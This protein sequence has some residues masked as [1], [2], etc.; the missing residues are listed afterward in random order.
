MASSDL[1]ICNSAL[2]EVPTTEIAALTETSLQAR[3]CRRSY[4]K[5]K[6][7]L[8][9]LPVRGWSFARGREALAVVANDRATEWRHAYRLPSG[10]EPLRI[11]AVPASLDEPAPAYAFT[12]LGTVKDETPPYLIAGDT[13]YTNVPE[14]HLDYRL[15]NVSEALF[16][17]YFVRALEMEL[18]SRLVMPITKDKVRWREVKAEAKVALDRALASDLNREPQRYFEHIPDTILARI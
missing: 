9:G 15:T 2:A 3:E 8:L 1:Q 12:A 17:E 11:V 16:P 4:A 18:A 10:K 7:Y 13:I 6:E 14:A 5:A